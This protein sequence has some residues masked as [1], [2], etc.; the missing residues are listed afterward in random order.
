MMITVN[1]IYPN[2]IG[3]NPTGFF[4]YLDSWALSQG[5]Q[6]PFFEINPVNT[7]EMDNYYH[8]VLS[9][10]K[11]ASSFLKKM[12]NSEP[13]TS[14]IAFMIASTWWNINKD[15]VIKEY[16]ILSIEYNPIENYK[17][18]ESGE[19]K[20][21]GT[22]TDAHTGTI[23][24]AHTGT[25]GDS[26]SHSDNTSVYAYDSNT[27]SPSTASSGSESNTRTHNDTETITRNN[28]DT[29]THNETKTHEFSRHGNIGVTTSQRM[30]GSERNLWLWNFY[31]KFLFPT[32]DEMLTVPYY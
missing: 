29:T 11:R 27:A 28:T 4:T 24:N 3:V 16:N 21:T 2:S 31:K 26:G 5:I 6:I 23:A 10:F 25:V 14:E 7:K 9:G 12:S 22:V 13:V 20:H 8:G 1:D 19:D 30:L 15:N 18:D 17:M 32:V